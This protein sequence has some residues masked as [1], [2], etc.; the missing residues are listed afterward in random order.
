MKGVWCAWAAF[1]LA[2]VY[3]VSGRRPWWIALRMQSLIPPSF[4]SESTNLSSVQN[5]NRLAFDSLTASTVFSRS[6]STVPSR[7]KT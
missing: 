1:K 5:A 3:A 4:K 7:R 2:I 6:R